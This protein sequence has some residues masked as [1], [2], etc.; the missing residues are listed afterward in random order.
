MPLLTTTA[1]AA[2]AST[3]S[4]APAKHVNHVLYVSPKGSKWAKDQ[5]CRTAAFKSI[6]SAVNAAPAGGT[7]VVCAGTYHEQV[8]VGKWLTLKGQRAVINEAGVKPGFKVTLPGLGKQTIYAGVVIVSSRV[9]FTGFTVTNAQG[10]GILAAGLFGPI[11]GLNISGNAVVHNDLGGGVP[12]KSPYFQCAA[13]GAVPGDCGEGLHLAGG[14]SYSTIHGN[15]VANNSGG[16]LVTDDVG[17]THNNL[18]SDNTVTGNSTDCGITVPGHNPLALNA[19]GKLQPA[20]AGVYDNVIKNNVVTNN[21]VKGAGSGVL[22]ANAAPGTAS[23]DN[24][25]E[26]NYIAGNGQS[27]VT[28]HAHKIGPNQFEDLNGNVIVGNAIGKNNLDGD[29]LDGPPGPSDLVTTGV[30]VYSGGTRVFVTIAHNHIF[31]NSIGIWLSKAVKA[32]GLKT[33]VFS[34][35]TTPVSG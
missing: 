26:G 8:V 20:V 24:L 1:I 9:T 4:A 15:F 23:Y 14:V 25:V 21:G 32:S 11:K 6:Q 19:K 2:Q 33:N 10:E 13:Q 7:V 3:A 12:P 30:L 5:S 17:P 22:F 35:V 34:N 18:I 27:G 28:M 29:T 31:N 16:I